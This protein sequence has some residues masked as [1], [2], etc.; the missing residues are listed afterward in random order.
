[1]RI[2]GRPDY[3]DGTAFRSDGRVLSMLVY[4][5]TDGSMREADARRA[6]SLERGVIRPSLRGADGTR[7]PPRL[8]FG[9]VRLR[10]NGADVSVDAC[11]AVFCGRLHS[12]ALVTSSHAL[13]NGREIIDRTWCWTS[14]DLE[15]EV[16]RLGMICTDDRHLPWFASRDVSDGARRLGITTATQDPSDRS[17]PRGTWRVEAATLGAMDFDRVLPP[18]DALAR[19]AHWSGG[20]EPGSRLRVRTRAHADA[21]ALHAH[22]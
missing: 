9:P 1:M 10:W 11:R 12:G 15:E 7:L 4:R 2:I 21:G 5:R 17:V 22:G 3:Y 6:F 14:D 16:G 19:L 18:S 13:P 20:E 8:P